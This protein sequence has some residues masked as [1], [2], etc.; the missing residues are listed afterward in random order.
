MNS[1]TGET[2]ITNNRIKSSNEIEIE[3]KQVSEIHTHATQTCNYCV[4]NMF[5]RYA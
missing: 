3:M 1:N 5:N 2:E 4:Q